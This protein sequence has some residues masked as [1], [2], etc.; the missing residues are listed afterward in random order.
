M[1]NRLKHIHL[2][3]AFYIV[4]FVFVVGYILYATGVSALLQGTQKT[5]LIEFGRN[6]Q[7]EDGSGISDIERIPSPEDGGEVV[8]RKKLPDDIQDGEALN[9]NSHN[10]YFTLRIGQEE[11]YKYYMG[12]NLTGKGYGDSLHNIFLLKDNAGETVEIRAISAFPGEKSS[13]FESV[14]ICDH[15][16]FYHRFVGNYGISAI[17]S[18][19]IIFFGIVVF[20]VRFGIVGKRMEY[21]LNALG[22][23]IILMG[24]WTLIETRI[25]QMLTG[26]T[27]FLR[28]VDYVLLWFAGYPMVVFVN[29]LT[30]KKRKIYDHL[31]FALTIVVIAANLI[32]RFGAGIDMHR[33]TLV[34]HG[35]FVLYLGFIG[36]ILY[37][38]HLYCKKEGLDDNMMFFYIGVSAFVAGGTLDMILYNLFKKSGMKSGMFLRM[39]LLLFIIMM[40]QQIM[41]WVSLE[42]RLNKRDRF[43]NNLLQYSMSGAS[44]EEI[45]NQ[46]LEY[47]GH[48]MKAERAYIFEDL[49]DGTFDNTYEWCKEGVVSQRENFQ[50]IPFEGAIDVWYR[51][52]EET[53]CVVITDVESY[54][55]ISGIGIYNYMKSRGVQTLATGPL[56]VRGKCIGFFGVDNPP[57]ELLTE[58]SESIRLL[59]YFITVV[60]R[61]RDDQN[62]LINYSYFDQMTGTKN[63]RAQQEYIDGELNRETSYGFVMCDI[64]GLKTVN[65]NLG[66]EEGD[67]MICDVAEVLL[68]VFGKNH[69]YRL[70]GDEFSAFGTWESEEDFAHAIENVR[71]LLKAKGRSASLGYVYRPEGD[72]DFDS[73]KNEADEKM[74]A[75]KAAYYEAHPELNRRS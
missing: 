9:F 59:A 25:P 62:E 66:H 73:V 32:L 71:A 24:G 38:N 54:N 23:T 35:S 36:H 5:H 19:L 44:P 56:E 64:N 4:L 53:K 52:F 20:T 50:G 45:I 72:A 11:E 26:A 31:A 60:L 34:A 47:L 55:D 46:M 65:D 37:T 22:T 1:K 2:L 51:E 15:H 61:Q 3:T 27:S 21:N 29:S 58:I 75:D 28:A 70:G 42:Q 7:L 48:E 67:R 68:M 14:M 17:L 40:F 57:A 18:L 13:G 49:W 69:V 39:G 33:L 43:I 74:Y 41:R 16:V 10:V 63:R 12:D 8:L 6:W 30:K